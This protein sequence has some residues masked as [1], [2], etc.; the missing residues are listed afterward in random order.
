VGSGS[1]CRF[2]Q[3]LHFTLYGVTK[4]VTDVTNL[5]TETNPPFL[6]FPF[7]PN[8]NLFSPRCRAVAAGRISHF[9]F[10]ALV[11]VSLLCDLCVHSR[12]RRRPLASS[13]A[14]SRYCGVGQR[15][16]KCGMQLTLPERDHPE[17]RL[18]I[19]RGDLASR[20]L[21]SEARG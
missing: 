21:R 12:L 8:L 16:E 6:H 7:S 3:F 11:A 14:K 1:F 19:E 15:V 20:R 18:L 9:G 2:E 5:V 4:R 17:G 10:V 13:S